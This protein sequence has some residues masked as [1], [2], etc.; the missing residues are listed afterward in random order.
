MR[1]LQFALLVHEQI[2]S[3]QVKDL[4]DDNLMCDRIVRN[5]FFEFQMTNPTKTSRRRGGKTHRRKACHRSSHYW[6]TWYDEIK[7]DAYKKAY[8]SFDKN[9]LLPVQ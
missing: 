6:T 3:D 2:L 7:S 4:R 9:K 8:V 1:F 5:I